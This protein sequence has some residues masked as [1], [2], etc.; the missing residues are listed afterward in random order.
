MD[1]IL[2][3]AIE[4]KDKL[5]NNMQTIMM[6]TIDSEGKPNSSYAPSVIDS[7][8]NYY[9]YISKL[10]KHTLNM[11]NNPNVSMMIIE[12]E[13]KTENVFGRK[14]FTMDSD[15]KV[16]DRDSEEWKE[17]ILLMENKFGETMTYLKDLTDFY[18]FKLK[19]ESGL[20]VHGFARAFKFVG[21]GLN[22][23]Q[24]LNDKGHNKK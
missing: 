17:V 5:I 3:T 10:S 1:E 16:I 22:E 6:S 7:C 13:S 9:V 19:P 14:R 20:L 15:V 18:L 23:I 12:D 21:D 24:Y 2:K 4:E 8:G 11:L